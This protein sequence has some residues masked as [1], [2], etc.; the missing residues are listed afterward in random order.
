[1]PRFE[2][3]HVML[4][5]VDTAGVMVG[6]GEPRLRSFVEKIWLPADAQDWP[7]AVTWGLPPAGHVVAEEYVVLPHPRMSRF[8]VPLSSRAVSTASLRHYNAARAPASR[9]VRSAVAGALAAGA[10]GL[11]RRSRLV[12]SV[13]S[14]VPRHRWHDLLITSRLA[15][16][17]GAERLHAFVAVREIN[18]NA[19]PTLQLFGDDAKPF[20]YAKLGTTAATKC[21]VRNEAA[22]MRRLGGRTD[23]IVPSLLS[24]GDWHD[25]AYAVSSPLPLDLRRCSGSVDET[26]PTLRQV[27]DSGDRS[28]GPV[29]GS[30]YAA[31]LR[32]DIDGLRDQ[33]GVTPLLSHWL[34]AVQHSPVSIPFGGYHGDWI[35]DN[36]GRSRDQFAVWDWEHSTPDAPAGFDLLHWHFHDA[37]ASSGLEAAVSAVDAAAPDMAALGV[38]AGSTR[39]TASLY[40]LDVSVRRAKLAAGGGGWNARWYPGILAVARSR[41]QRDYASA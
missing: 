22:A 38:P 1:M 18:P 28:F 32:S 24:S 2:G 4:G 29:A 35:P 40:L 34:Q 33:D 7:V 15:Q 25:T 41:G 10:G 31:R 36:M 6:S 12:V 14:R 8:L 37:L 9:A 16:E 5:A 13:D 20:G 11:A 39:L 26:L 23:P 19:K 30:S 21:L 27:I 17:L 3:D